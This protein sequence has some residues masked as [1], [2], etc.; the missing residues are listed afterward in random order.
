MKQIY[1]KRQ[2][3]YFRRKNNFFNSTINFMTNIREF[4]IMIR[5]LKNFILTSTW[6][7]LQQPSYADP[8]WLFSF[9]GNL[10]EKQLLR[11]ECIASLAKL[12]VSCTWWPHTFKLCFPTF[13]FHPYSY[14][15]MKPL[16]LFHSSTNILIIVL[17][18]FNLI[19]YRIFKNLFHPT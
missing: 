9:M 11:Y 18:D 12:N 7:L 5:S 3:R 13:A 16:S 4:I 6:K 10:W 1:F 15:P 19:F 8:H 17:L 2:G 14:Q